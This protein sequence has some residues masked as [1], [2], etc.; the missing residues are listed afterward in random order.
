M[1]NG[2]IIDVPIHDCTSGILRGDSE[3]SPADTGQLKEIT[4]CHVGRCDRDAWR[5]VERRRERDGLCTRSSAD[6][7]LL[8]RSALQ[9]DRHTELLNQNVLSVASRVE[10]DL[11][12]EATPTLG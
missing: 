8:F 10:L 7:A 11:E 1:S 4:A 9:A 3:A 6:V 2:L 12:L 5:A